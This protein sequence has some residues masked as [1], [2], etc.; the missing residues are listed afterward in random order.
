[1]IARTDRF[2]VFKSDQD[3]AVIYE[4]SAHG[5]S[6]LR[7]VQARSFWEELMALKAINDSRREITMNALC[8]TY[9]VD[10][11]AEMSLVERS[12]MELAA[13]GD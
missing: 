2:T 7:G 1:M 4:K 5:K 10:P 9:L 12:F 13:L 11:I 6:V 3:E 8:E